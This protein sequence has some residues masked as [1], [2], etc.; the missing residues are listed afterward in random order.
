LTFLFLTSSLCLG[1]FPAT[2][3]T[4]GGHLSSVPPTDG[5]TPAVVLLSEW[6]VDRG[7]SQV[8]TDGGPAS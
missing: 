7:T 1:E 5:V 6:S 3:L 8:T 2:V 4:I